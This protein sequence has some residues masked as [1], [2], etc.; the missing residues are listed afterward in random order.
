MQSVIPVASDGGQNILGSEMHVLL[1][2]G[3]AESC[4]ECEDP[5]WVW[6][7]LVED[8]MCTWNRRRWNGHA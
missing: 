5:L 1:S 2:A 6:L 7:A 4:H 8:S 3:W